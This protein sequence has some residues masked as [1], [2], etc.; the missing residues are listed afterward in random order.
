[1]DRDVS[2]PPLQ[3]FVFAG[4]LGGFIGLAVVNFL[5]TVVTLGIYRFWARARV[6]RYL[7]ENTTFAGEPLEYS[8]KGIE[9]LI[10]AILGFIIILVPY[11]GVQLVAG[12]LI[13]TQH[14]LLAG[15]LGVAVAAAIYYLIGVGLYRSE[16]YMLSRTSWRGIRG[17]M[18]TGGW[19]YGW[20]YLRLQLLRV[21]TLGLTTPYVSIRLWN[22]RM[23]DA[24][25]GSAR[26]VANAQWKPLYGRFLLAFVGAVVIYGAAIGVLISIEP[27]TM[28]GHLDPTKPADMRAMLPFLARLYG[29]LFGGA[30]LIGLVALSYHAAY[31]RQIIGSIRIETLGLEFD[32]SAASWFTYYLVNFLIVVLTLG[33]GVA[34]L[35][36]RAWSFYLRHLRT[37]GSLDTDMLLQTQLTAPTQGDGIADA[38]GFSLMPF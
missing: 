30:I 15:L 28:T 37:I 10:G 34:V 25:F 38:I 35:P 13:A 8:G 17:G 21:V 1:M 4:S 24:M 27:G 16:R 26:V 11:V 3:R 9:L 18:I 33:L 32:A 2:P 20:L 31:Y 7:W 12:V 5:L 6:R 19:S 29:I 23:N 22:A 36:W 14:P